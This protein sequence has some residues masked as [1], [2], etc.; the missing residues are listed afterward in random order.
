[1]GL[2]PPNIFI[3]QCLINRARKQFNANAKRTYAA[4]LPGWTPML[5]D[6]Y[7]DEYDDEYDANEYDDGH[8]MM[9]MMKKIMMIF[10]IVIIIMILE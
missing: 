7:D 8:M 6:A 2:S 4:G 5:Y 10:R 9:S 1:M 3:L